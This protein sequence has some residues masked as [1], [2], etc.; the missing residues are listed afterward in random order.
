MT[1]AGPRRVVPSWRKWEEYLE[2]FTCRWHA[3]CRRYVPSPAISFSRCFQER[4]IFSALR[5]RRFLSMYLIKPHHEHSKTE[6]VFPEGSCTCGLARTAVDMAIAI[7]AR[8]GSPRLHLWSGSAR[9]RRRARL[10]MEGRG[11]SLCCLFHSLECHDWSR[12]RVN[13]MPGAVGEPAESSGGSKRS[14][15]AGRIISIF[16]KRT[17]RALSSARLL[18][19]CLNNTEARVGSE[20]S[21]KAR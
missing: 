9:N 11:A 14:L 21:S 15:W 1:H 10:G 16:P 3:H 6:P 7:S 20:L 4:G 17:S 13:R 19:A 18:Q 8:C 12:F 2:S 5:C